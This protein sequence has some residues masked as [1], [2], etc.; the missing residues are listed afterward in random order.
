[1]SDSLPYEDAEKLV[2]M[3]CALPG[4]A[5]LHAGTFGEVSLLYPGRRVR[6]L[7][8][9]EGTHLEVHLVADL[10]AAPDLHDLAREVRRAVQS[11]TGFTV[12][13]IIA[14]AVDSTAPET[15]STDTT[16]ARDAS[17]AP[18]APRKIS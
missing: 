17:S 8:L 3:V 1:M 10:A 12:D 15:A 6:G 11:A 2:R 9:R 4:V 18:R 7:R 13:V 14:D 5:D 16:K